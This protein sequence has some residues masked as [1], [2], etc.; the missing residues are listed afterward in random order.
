M[1]A[2]FGAVVNERRAYGTSCS[3][4]AGTAHAPDTLLV[5]GDCADVDRTDTFCPTLSNFLKLVPTFLETLTFKNY[6]SEDSRDSVIRNFDLSLKSTT[7][8]D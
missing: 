5:T 4:A 6:N 8:L 2:F 7:F 3:G 1:K